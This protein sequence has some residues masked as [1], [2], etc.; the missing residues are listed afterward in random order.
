MALTW[1]QPRNRKPSNMK[2]HIRFRLLTLMLLSTITCIFVG[3][4]GNRVYRARRLTIAANQIRDHG[5]EAIWAIPGQFG[6]VYTQANNKYIENGG[7]PS[8][9]ARPYPVYGIIGESSLT[10]S[11]LERL[12]LE[13]VWF[14]F[15]RVTIH[16]DTFCS[17]SSQLPLA[18]DFDECTISEDG[19]ASFPTNVKWLTISDCDAPFS[20]FHKLSKIKAL[21]WCR[22]SFSSLTSLEN[23]SEISK[24]DSIST[25]VLTDMRLSQKD[26]QSFCGMKN[27]TQL[28]IIRCEIYEPVDW[29]AVLE[30]SNL[31][32]LSTYSSGVPERVRQSVRK[33]NLHWPS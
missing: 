6:D 2:I 20:L 33:P 24:S 12:S 21:E 10:P 13:P 25:L 4:I 27:L 3:V 17:Y 23:V 28:F 26:I 31:R 15:L 18:L 5:G 11:Y 32:I 22:I 14:Q 8:L 7:A 1:P 16:S 9:I 30:N 29:A 19:L